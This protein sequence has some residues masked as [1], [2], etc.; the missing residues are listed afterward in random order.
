MVKQHHML[1]SKVR[2]GHSPATLVL[3]FSWERIQSQELNYKQKSFFKSF[4]E[5]MFID[6]LERQEGGDR[7]R[8]S[9]ISCL[10]CVLQLGIKPTTLV[11]ALTGD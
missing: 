4:P 10:P 1:T 6:F 9:F 11:P 3:D 2:P 7:E 8:K 5:E